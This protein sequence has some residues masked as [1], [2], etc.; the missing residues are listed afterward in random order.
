[1]PKDYVGAVMELCQERRG[2]HVG[3][4][5]FSPTRVQ[6]QYDLPLAE[7]VLDF[8][9][10]LKSKTKG[11]ASLDYELLGLRP[12]DLVKLDMLLAGDPVDALSMVVHKDKAY[13]LGRQMTERL[14]KQIPR[15]QFEVAIQ[16]SIGTERHRARV[17]QGGAQG[18]DR[19]VLRRRHHAQEE[20]AREAEG[21]QEAHEAGRAHRGAARG[22][23]RRADARRRGQRQEVRLLAAAGAAAAVLLGGCTVGSVDDVKPGQ[24]AIEL[25]VESYLQALA[26]NQP[27]RACSKLTVYFQQSLKP[28]CVAHQRQLASVRPLRFEGQPLD[29]GSIDDLHW[30]IVVNGD[31][32]TATGQYHQTAFK[33]QKVP[34]E[35]WRIDSIGPAAG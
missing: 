35:G 9:D 29:A 21:R 30:T 2:T 28:S 1:M 24:T 26:Q 27:A 10:Q 31:F 25:Q 32:A 12:G 18:R 13:A 22:V 11:Y 8:F 33:L 3:M 34:G 7:I 14:R 6:I 5:F 4:S 15:Q 23:P 16:A 17:G 19:Q 20:A